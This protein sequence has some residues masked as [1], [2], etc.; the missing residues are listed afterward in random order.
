MVFKVK[1]IKDKASGSLT[2]QLVE[3]PEVISEGTSIAELKSNLID[4]LRLVL[5]V[6]AEL[7]KSR[8]TIGKASGTAKKKSTS[9][10][11]ELTV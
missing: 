10:L 8:K 2:G 1:I 3:F 9:D 4:A 5:D 7:K 6:K 11:Y